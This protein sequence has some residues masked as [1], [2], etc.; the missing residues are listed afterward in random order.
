MIWGGIAGLLVIAAILYFG[1]RTPSGSETAQVASGGRSASTQ[2]PV[3]K[4][5]PGADTKT[6]M[7]AAQEYADRKEYT[8]AEEIYK[9]VVQAEPDNADALKALA[10]VLYREDKLAESAAVLDKIK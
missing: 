8:V 10:S 4:L 7:R 1:V 6:K 5:P 2:A 9:Q 3:A